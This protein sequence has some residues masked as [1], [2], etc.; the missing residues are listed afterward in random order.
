MSRDS[1]R[2]YDRAMV[3]WTCPKPDREGGK[4]FKPWEKTKIEFSN[5]L[6]KCNIKNCHVK[7]TCNFA[8][9][10]TRK[11]CEVI[12]ID[13]L[14]PYQVQLLDFALTLPSC[15]NNAGRVKQRGKRD[16]KWHRKMV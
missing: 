2:I 10:A 15:R 12:T 8:F 7:L 11:H 3:P 16:G 5:I 1:I 6:P 13:H 4:I 14:L 9:C